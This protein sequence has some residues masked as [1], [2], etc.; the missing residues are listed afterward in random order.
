[1]ST[2]P[3]TSA[4]TNSY[5]VG[6][7]RGDA[8]SSAQLVPHTFGPG[9]EAGP[10]NRNQPPPFPLAAPTRSTQTTSGHSVIDTVLSTTFQPQ[11][12]SQTFDQAQSDEPRNRLF[13]E[14]VLVAPRKFNIFLES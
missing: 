5:S 13:D 1:M 2:G 4:H 12:P 3:S 8:I 10:R 6:P 14:Y 9:F 7:P 11:V